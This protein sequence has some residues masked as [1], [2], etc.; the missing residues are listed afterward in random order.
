MLLH[1]SNCAIS[2]LLLSLPKGLYETQMTDY[3]VTEEA[4]LHQRA[5]GILNVEAAFCGS[6]VLERTQHH[7]SFT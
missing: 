2:R 4:D 5:P 1:I 3:L 7:E 6:T